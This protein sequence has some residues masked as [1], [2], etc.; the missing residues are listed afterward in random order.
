MTLLFNAI[1][2]L[3]EKVGVAPRNESTA[4]TVD[5]LFLLTHLKGGINMA[6]KDP[7]KVKEYSSYWRFINKDKIQAEKHKYYLEHKESLLQKAKDWRKSN[8]DKAYA[9]SRKWVKNNIEKVRKREREWRRQDFLK[10]PDKWRD[11]CKLWRKNNPDKIRD[12][13]AIVR[14]RKRNATIEKFSSLEIYERDKW[15]CQLCKKKVNKKLKWPNP[16]SAS[17]DHIIALACKGTHERKNVQLAHLICNA[18]AQ[19]KGRQP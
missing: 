16:L 12:C 19:T 4:L 5:L 11:K 9:N 8:P 10:D 15:I 17:L 1:G 18:L 3:K 13:N 6:F 14:A 7:T 2:L